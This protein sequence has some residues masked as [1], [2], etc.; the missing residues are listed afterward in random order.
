MNDHIFL[1]LFLALFTATILFTGDASCQSKWSLTGVV[2]ELHYNNIFHS[3]RPVESA[4]IAI[5]VNNTLQ[6]NTTSTSDGHFYCATGIRPATSSIDIHYLTD[7]ELVDS[8]TRINLS[9]N[10]GNVE[11]RQVFLLCKK[12]ALKILSAGLTEKVKS[13]LTK[14]YERE[15]DHLKTKYKEDQKEQLTRALRDLNHQYELKY[16]LSDS[17]SYVFARMDSSEINAAIFKAYEFYFK[18][19]FDSTIRY[20][21]PQTILDLGTKAKLELNQ[22]VFLSLLRADLCADRYAQ[23][24]RRNSDSN[25]L[26]EANRFYAYANELKDYNDLYSLEKL[27]RF[28][29]YQDDYKQAVPL[30]KRSLLLVA[31]TGG[32]LD[33]SVRIY[34][35]LSYVYEK[36]AEKDSSDSVSEY[37]YNTITT[38]V[39]LDKKILGTGNVKS[40]SALYEAYRYFPRYSSKTNPAPILNTQKKMLVVLRSLEKTGVK[41][42]DDFHAS[43]RSIDRYEPEIDVDAEIPEIYRNLAMQ[44]IMLHKKDS[45]IHYFNAE[46]DFYNACFS[47]PH[48]EDEYEDKLEA[49]KMSAMF[50]SSYIPKQVRSIIFTREIAFLKPLKKKKFPGE[51]NENIDEAITLLKALIIQPIKIEDIFPNSPAFQASPHPPAYSPLSSP[52]WSWRQI[53][54]LPPYRE[55]H[56]H[57]TSFDSRQSRG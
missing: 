47:Q 13:V 20:L 43:R 57:P 10:D 32:S 2:K 25:D 27:I 41:P 8:S 19:Q 1:K 40:L 36:W 6:C 4:N 34:S 51:T 29:I 44:Y 31:L 26:M 22:A 14:E 12:D 16:R 53:R 17:L 56:I 50:I 28:L 37:Q 42:H 48:T 24:F 45:A 21:N 11:S 7:Y 49:L 23:N 15:L 54:Q 46:Y 38:I 18:G 9:W 39:G 3:V 33:D 55:I 30:L 35:D 52:D 5:S